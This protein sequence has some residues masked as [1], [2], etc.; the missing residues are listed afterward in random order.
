[1]A[2]L[3]KKLLVGATLAAGVTALAS[4]PA[5]AGSLTGASITGVN[6]TDY[7][8]YDANATNTYRNDAASLSTILTGSSSSP[9]GNVELFANSETLNN[10]AFST[11]STVTTL[12]GQIGGRNIT[13]SS[14]TAADWATNV[15]GG[16]TLAQKWFNDALTNNGLGSL[17]GT[18][19]GNTAY[20][21][22]QLSG[23]RQR[24]SDA[25]ISYVNQNDTTGQ[26]SIGLAGHLD[27]KSL[28]LPVVP[29]S[30]QPLLAGKTIQASEIVKVS[31]D[32]GPAQ[33]L[34]NFSATNSGLVEQ[35]DGISHTGNYEL[36][37]AGIPPAKVPEPSAMLGLMGVGGFLA[38]KRKMKNA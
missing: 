26:I 16:L 1:M 2:G 20:T 14:L 19:T 18:T 25:N 35:G 9:T 8:L 3:V 29:P 24:F 12:S 31:Y 17:I 23:G 4:A 10:T 34:Y 15:G 5:K 27:A 6:G 28:L 30:L 22:F 38:A 32:G 36:L 7:Y 33:Y 11:Y 37:L 13:L 21:S